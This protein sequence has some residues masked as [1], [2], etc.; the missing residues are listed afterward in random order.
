ML[1]AKK[2]ITLKTIKNHATAIDVECDI[3]GVY[4]FMESLP[5]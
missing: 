5:E 2:T 4:V 1:S 3:N